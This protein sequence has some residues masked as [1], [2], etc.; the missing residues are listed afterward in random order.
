MKKVIQKISKY[1]ITPLVMFLAFAP[2]GLAQIFQGSDETGKTDTQKGV[3][4]IKDKLS[5]SGVTGTSDIGDLILKYV[6]F[7]LPYL[8][9]AAFVGF[10]YAG[11][12][13]VTAFGSDDQTQKAKKVMIYAVA[14]LIL[15]ILS[16]SIVQLLTTDLVQGIQSQ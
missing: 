3:D 15:V 5:G 6:N 12:L 14:G 1:I 10:V 11:V 9:I 4:T 13:Y 2:K 7:I 16:Y 8:A